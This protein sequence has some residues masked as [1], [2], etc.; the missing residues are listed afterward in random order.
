MYI[1]LYM[2]LDYLFG[3]LD[4][5][6]C[7][8]FYILSVFA[9]ISILIIIIGAIIMILQGKISIKTMIPII[10]A[11]LMYFV[12]YFQSRLLYSMCSRREN[13]SFKDVNKKRI[14]KRKNVNYYPNI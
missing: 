6:Y 13:L 10:F 5:E 14:S 8:Y 7:L 3:P 11:A 2:I 12:F 9:F 4:S 1:I